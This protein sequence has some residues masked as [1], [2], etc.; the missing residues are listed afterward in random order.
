M[1]GKRIDGER[2]TGWLMD[3]LFIP[4]HANPPDCDG[5]DGFNAD[6][7]DWSNFMDLS[8]SPRSFRGRILHVFR[9]EDGHLKI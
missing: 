8:S 1:R 3:G 7:L 6:N 4:I 9:R 2:V 5:V